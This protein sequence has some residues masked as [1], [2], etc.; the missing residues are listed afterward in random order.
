MICT[1]IVA[2]ITFLTVYCVMLIASIYI[3]IIIIMVTVSR[4]DIDRPHK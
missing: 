1:L 2:L 4:Y 3:P